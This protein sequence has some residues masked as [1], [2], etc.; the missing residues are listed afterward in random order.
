MES[1]IK[2]LFPAS[3]YQPRKISKA[4]FSNVFLG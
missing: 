1:T 2:L 4:Y 3:E